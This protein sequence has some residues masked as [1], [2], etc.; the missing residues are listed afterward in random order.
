MNQ[1]G[2]STVI[3]GIK[4]PVQAEMNTRALIEINSEDLTLLHSLFDEKYNKL[5]DKMI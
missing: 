5:I 4:T 1:K 2:I 3:P